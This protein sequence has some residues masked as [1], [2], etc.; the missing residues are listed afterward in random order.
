LQTEE[1]H[2]EARGAPGV[3]KSGS[4]SIRAGNFGSDVSVSSPARPYRPW[5]RG[6][7]ASRQPDAGWRKP[8]FLGEKSRGVLGNRMTIVTFEKEVSSKSF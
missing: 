8:S 6:T 2:S 3:N 5:G 7:G 4:L 1:F